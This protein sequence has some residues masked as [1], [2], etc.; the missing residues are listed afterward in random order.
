VNDLGALLRQLEGCVQEEIGA[1]ARALERLTAQSAAL[2]SG[3]AP[4]LDERTRELEAE[5]SGAGVRADRRAALLRKLAALWAVDARVLTLGSIVLRSGTEG[6]RLG[7]LRSELRQAAAR[8]A[9]QLRRNALAA[10]LHQRAWGEILEGTLSAV[11]GE[12]GMTGGRLVDA[13]A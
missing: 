11:A 3:D 6:Q 12:Q 7:R 2:R 4:R 1:Q 9:R 10:R 8:T 13:E 5:L